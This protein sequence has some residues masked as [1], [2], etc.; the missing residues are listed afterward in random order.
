MH[1]SGASRCGRAHAHPKLFGCLKI[2]SG[3]RRVGKAQ[4]AHH[5][6]AQQPK[7]L[8]WWARRKRALPTLQLLAVISLLA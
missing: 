7:Y 2:A 8:G 5:L 4:R 1:N 6:L 3:I